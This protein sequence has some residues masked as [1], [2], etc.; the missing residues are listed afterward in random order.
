[1]SLAL[2]EMKRNKGRFFIVGSIVFLIS[3]SLTL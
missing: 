1:M 3:A 2:K